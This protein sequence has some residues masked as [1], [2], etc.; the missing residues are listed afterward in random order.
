[1]SGYV[2][3]SCRDCFEIAISGDDETVPAMC[4]ECE[5]AGCEPDSEC[6]VI[7]EPEERDP[8]DVYKEWRDS[9]VDQLETEGK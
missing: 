3:C 6:E 5:G 2:D 4:W 8:I 7:R 1:M 9:Q